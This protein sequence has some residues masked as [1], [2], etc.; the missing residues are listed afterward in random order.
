MKPAIC[1]NNNNSNNNS[2]SSFGLKKT[3]T[4]KKENLSKIISRDRRIIKQTA[5]QNSPTC[6][7]EEEPICWCG[8]QTCQ[9][10]ELISLFLF[11]QMSFCTGSTF[12][13]FFLS[14]THSEVHPFC[15]SSWK[16]NPFFSLFKKIYIKSTSLSYICS[17]NIHTTNKLD[18]CHLQIYNSTQTDFAKGTDTNTKNKDPRRYALFASA[19]EGRLRIGGP[20]RYLPGFL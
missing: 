8:A 14:K 6:D 15:Q 17:L 18:I 9:S 13:F 12:P 10:Q 16:I 20:A 3:K 1:K 11:S 19:C 7:P 5:S 2:D 4:K